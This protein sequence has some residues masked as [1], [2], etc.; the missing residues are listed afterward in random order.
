MSTSWNNI[1][2][3]VRHVLVSTLLVVSIGTVV[4]IGK[5]FKEKLVLTLDNINSVFTS[6]E[7]PNIRSD[8]AEI[9]KNISEVTGETNK[10]LVSFNDM[11]HSNDES[12]KVEREKFGKNISDLMENL[13]KLLSQ[14]ANSEGKGGLLRAILK[15]SK[16]K[17][18]PN[19][20]HA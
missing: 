12:G 16:N 7:F 20:D 8:I 6:S 1:F 10:A 14:L 13:N 15:S 19:H 5:T 17:T 18:P 2:T 9:I 3:I 11:V 4:Y